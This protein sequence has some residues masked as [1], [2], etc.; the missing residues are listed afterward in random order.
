M[1]IYIYTYTY[2]YIYIHTY[3]YTYGAAH[4]AHASAGATHHHISTMNPKSLKTRLRGIQH[5]INLYH[6]IIRNGP[7][8]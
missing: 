4:R 2:M 1:Y 8:K 7:V 6:K 3:V 5:K